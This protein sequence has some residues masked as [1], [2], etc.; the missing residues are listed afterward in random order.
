MFRIRVRVKLKGSVRIGMVLGLGCG[1]LYMYSG[2]IF[3][4]NCTAW[5]LLVQS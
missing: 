4:T 2:N 1:S 3:T 5:L